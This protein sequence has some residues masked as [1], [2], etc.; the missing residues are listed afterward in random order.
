MN[1]ILPS[2]QDEDA[3]SSEGGLEAVNLPNGHT[4][5]PSEG[6]RSMQ[7]GAGGLLSASSPSTPLFPGVDELLAL[8]KDS[9]KELVS[10]RQQV[11]VLYCLFLLKLLRKS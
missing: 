9:S 6:G 10:L 1:E 4:R 3:E 2:F 8:F 7:G 11:C 5:A